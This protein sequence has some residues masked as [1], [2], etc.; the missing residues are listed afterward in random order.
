MGVMPIAEGAQAGEADLVAR[1]RAGSDAA[2]EEL[3]RAQGARLLAVARRLLRSEEDARDAVQD[4]FISAFRA[5][6]RFEGGS[7]LSTWL[8]RIVVNAALM[9]LR[10]QQRK[11]ETSIEDL[12]PRFLEDGHFAEPPAEWQ[13]SADRA[14]ERRETR[15]LVRQAIDGLPENYRTVLLLRDIEG[16]DTAETA[17]ALGVTA[18]AVKIR[19]HRARQAL[20]EQLDEHM[21]EDAA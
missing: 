1:L 12:L 5:I 9:K 3:V 19:L 18:N 4:A 8:H 20:R 14:L 16:L 7:R 6:D 10:S 13:Q 17:E 15:E 11:P 2:Y 21:R